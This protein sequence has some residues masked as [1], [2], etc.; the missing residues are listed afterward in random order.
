[1][2]KGTNLTASINFNKVHFLDKVEYFSK[3]NIVPGGTKNNLQFY[4]PN[5]KFDKNIKNYQKLM[6]ADAQTSGG[7]LISTSKNNSNSL[8]DSLNKNSN[9]KTFQIGEFISNKNFNISVTNG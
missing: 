7:L 8:I 9:Y 5:I 1:M 6:L 2:C 4:E 3:N